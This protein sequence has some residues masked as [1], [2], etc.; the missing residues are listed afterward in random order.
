[1]KAHALG[2][3]VLGDG[4][5]D[6]VPWLGTVSKMFT[7][8]GSGAQATQAPGL[9]SSSLAAQ[10]AARR[11]IEE[12]R[13]RRAEADAAKMRVVVYGLIGALG[14]GAAVWVLKK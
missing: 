13:L 1:M 9:A 14:V 3:Q 2:M 11:V 5:M 8:G 10:E 6:F 4:V 12:E 7:G